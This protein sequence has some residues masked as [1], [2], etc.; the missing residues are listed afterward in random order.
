MLVKLASAS[1]IATSKGLKMIYFALNSDGLMYNLGDH[2]DY[3]AATDTAEN[4]KLEVIWLFCE[5]EA[6]NIANFV[7]QELED[8]DFCIYG[9]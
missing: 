5:D 8:Q 2:G 9:D 4:L 1:S 7:Q 3:E 6:R